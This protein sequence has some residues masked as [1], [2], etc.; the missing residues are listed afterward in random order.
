LSLAFHKIDE[1]LKGKLPIPIVNPVKV[2]VKTAEILVDL[3]L[4]H[5]KLA[6]PNPKQVY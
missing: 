6:F 3:G 5:S 1:D 4:A 2:A